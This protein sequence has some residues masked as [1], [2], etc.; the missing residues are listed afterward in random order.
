MKLILAQGN[1]GSQYAA[2]RHNAGFYMIDAFGNAQ[3]ATWIEKSKF[4]ALIAEVHI[5]GEKVI[6]AKPTT[7]YNET[8]RSARAIADFYKS[9]PAEDILVIHDELALPF[10]TVRT[11][12]GGSDA[13]NN[14]VKSLNAA[15][16]QEY[17]RIRIGIWN[18]GREKMDDV[19]F[20][21]GRF[22]REE[23]EALPKLYE[24]VQQQIEA[25]IADSHVDETVKLL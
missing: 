18:E 2:T 17:K 22:S 9:D 12:S 14:G 23:T 3:G 16:G 5:D 13:G 19:D 7:Y 4:T 20:V 11:R 15:L 6:L 25:F 21:L 24:L 1:P 8:G 10:G